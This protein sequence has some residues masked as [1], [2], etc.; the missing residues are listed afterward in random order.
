MM[1]AASSGAPMRP[2]GTSGRV[3]GGNSFSSKGVSKAPGAS[4]FTRTPSL[5]PM[6]ASERPSPSMPALA[7]A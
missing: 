4:T 7:A 1:P 6:S 3:L 2:S 5:A